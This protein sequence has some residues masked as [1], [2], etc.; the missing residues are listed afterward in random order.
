VCARWAIETRGEDKV[1]RKPQFTKN[2]SDLDLNNIRQKTK[3]KA[4]NTS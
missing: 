4:K 2:L 1:E 3:C